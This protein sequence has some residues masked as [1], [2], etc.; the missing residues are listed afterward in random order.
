VPVGLN[1]AASAWKAAPG[2]RTES[3]SMTPE[4]KLLLCCARILRSHEDEAAI[5]GM[6]DDGIDWTL[7][8]R[9]AIDHGLA[10]FAGHTLSIAAPDGVPEAILDA[11]RLNLDRARNRNRVLFDRLAEIME[12]LSKCGIEAIPFKGPVLALQAYGDVGFRVFRDLDFLVRDCDI[13]ATMKT[14][15]SLGYERKEGLTEAQVEAIQRLQ[16]QDFLYNKAAGIG[17]EPHTRLTSNRIALDIDYAGLW[18]RARR[19]TLNAH[20]ML[21]PEPEDHFLILAIHGG[22]ELWWNIK[23]SCD[24]A[25][26]IA[27]HP[28][29]N[30]TKIVERARAQGCLRMVLLAAS[31]ARTYFDAAVPETIGAA[32]I[33]DTAIGP[34]TERILAR[35]LSDEAGG[36]PSNGRLSM[37][38]L[39]LH[40]GVVRRARYAA[41]TWLLPGP[42]YVALVALP[43]QLSF[44]YVPLK[45][46][47]DLALFPLW[48]IYR[49]LLT[50]A[51]ARQPQRL[52]KLR[53]RAGGL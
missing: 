37:D 1:I 51:G 42:Q 8:A 40:D 2:E 52:A 27:S 17:V 15:R 36:P 24:I 28:D 38:R 4:L 5:G 11:F 12:T 13:A 7:F 9:M 39:R 3:Q 21:T 31:L 18:Q 47:H 25:A 19:M 46:V 33:A 53:R 10:G 32:Q 23:W 50:R 14:L 44:A 20:T 29:L 6:L 34:M 43:R 48:R 49:T 16:G 26:F 41:R 35:W 22:K 45:F 30:W